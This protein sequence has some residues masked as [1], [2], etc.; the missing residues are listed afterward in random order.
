MSLV[1][2]T[3]RNLKTSGLNRASFLWINSESQNVRGTN[4]DFAYDI[5]QTPLDKN[6]A[7]NLHIKSCT[8]PN[9]SPQITAAYNYNRIRYEIVR[10][11][12]LAVMTT[13]EIQIEQGT[14][15]SA[16][17][18]F[19]LAAVLNQ[20]FGSLSGTYGGD[21]HTIT[22]SD[23]THRISVRR[24]AMTPIGGQTFFVRLLANDT[25]SQYNGEFGFGMGFVLGIAYGGVLNLPTLTGNANAVVCPNPP[26]LQPYLYFSILLDGVNN[27]MHSS[28]TPAI[29]QIVFRA[30]LT[31]GAGRYSYG[32][33]E[34]NN[35]DFGQLYV[36]TLP[37]QL[38]FRIIDQYGNL[39]PM[40]ENGAL[41]LCIKLTPIE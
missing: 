16:Q 30:P 2:G 35:P 22:Y 1:S 39:F 20:D 33:I 15:D 38:R 28:D 13:R 11:S 17:L 40:A 9:V 21:A 27:Y 34:E 18:V 19:N 25:N 32:Y 37:S 3:A 10:L 5:T 12:D 6:K 23:I 4:N 7:Y 41:D 26:N 29:N 14:Y 36:S 8:F 31:V 24:D